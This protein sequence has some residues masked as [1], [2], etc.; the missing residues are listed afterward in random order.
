M[1]LRVNGVEFEELTAD[2][3]APVEGQ[4]WYNTTA[5]EFKVYRNSVVQVLIYAT[6]LSSHVS[7]ANPHSVTLE[8]ARTAGATLAGDINMG[9]NKITALAPAVALTDAPTLGQVVDQINSKLQGLDWQENVL[10]KDLAVPPIGPAMGD[11]YLI[12]GKNIDAII[13]AD[14]GLETVT[15]AGDVTSLL[16]ATDTFQIVGSTGN[17]GTYTVASA[18]FGGVN[19]VITVNEDITDATADGDIEYT[20]GD[21]NNQFNNIAEWDGA[22]WIITVPD[23]NGGTALQVQDEGLVYIHDGTNW[24]QFGSAIDHGSLLG[25]GDDDHTIYVLADGTRAFTGNVNMGGNNITNVGTVDGVTV[26]NHKAR[27]I[28]GGG[29]EIDGDKL[30]ITWNPTNYTPSVTP[31][32]V[33]SVDEL[34][35][36]LAGIDNAISTSAPK[37]KAG[38]V[39][40]GSFAGNPKKATVAFGAAFADAN[41]AVT[42]TA[43]T[44]GNSSF[45]LAIESQIAASFVI[46]AGAN[47]IANLTQ[48]NWVAIKDG[49]N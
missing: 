13:A 47:N 23:T 1:A 2:P 8:Q 6:T 4:L 12:L 19:T 25:L 30:G 17:D 20:S 31:P 26:S 42:A 37:I 3:G 15:V 22:A 46:N 16:A 34:T 45:A 14:T 28:L 24:A 41:Y 10:D 5:K 36:H 38:R 35:A 9:S 33:T 49:E 18:V 43:V 29:D 7:D 39:L 32:E 44:T 40:A 48:V 21:W 11:R 27:H